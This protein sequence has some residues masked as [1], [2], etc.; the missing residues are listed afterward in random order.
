M[1]IYILLFWLLIV[2][3][4]HKIN[5]PD[6]AIGESAERSL[7]SLRGT[8][9]SA[10]AVFAPG[11]TTKYKYTHTHIQT[12]QIKYISTYVFQLFDL[13]LTVY[14]ILFLLFVNNLS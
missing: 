5:Q 4:I 14:T 3:D 7:E 1:Y 8:K 10:Y 2:K 11:K 12:D 13:L 6:D 9:I